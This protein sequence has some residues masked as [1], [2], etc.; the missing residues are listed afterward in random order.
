MGERGRIRERGKDMRERKDMGYTGKGYGRYG[1][2]MA[3][4]KDMGE[5][6]DIP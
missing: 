3:E 6:K 5:R 1:K 4:R 2:D